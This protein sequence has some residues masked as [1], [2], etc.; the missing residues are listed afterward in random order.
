MKLVK[1]VMYDVFVMS[2]FIFVWCIQCFT[3]LPGDNFYYLKAN[4]SS[5]L[6]INSWNITNIWRVIA[7]DITQQKQILECNKPKQYWQ[8]HKHG[9]AN[10]M[11]DDIYLEGKQV[12]TS[13][14]K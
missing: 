10:C 6:I 1:L 2:S 7:T 11:F 5:S 3:S 14:L 12:E 9:L 13:R 4:W 8:Q